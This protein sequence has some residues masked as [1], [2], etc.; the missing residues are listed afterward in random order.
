[1]AY[2]FLKLKNLVIGQF[3]E[4]SNRV[5]ASERSER[6]NLSKI[7]SSL[8]LL[9]MTR[10]FSRAGRLQNFKNKSGQAI[11]ETSISF[12]LMIALLCGILKVWF[13]FNSNM[14]K[15]QIGYNATRVHA[16]TS[17]DDYTLSWP[18]YHDKNDPAEPYRPEPLTDKDIMLLD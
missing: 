12:V 10:I 15:R 5:I 2:R 1:M 9:A 3:S 16:G 7:A 4:T 8:S 14:V 11:L 13:W 6:S 17:R 18:L